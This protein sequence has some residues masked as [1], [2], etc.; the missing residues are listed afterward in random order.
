MSVKQGIIVPQGLK[1][2]IIGIE[3]NQNEAGNSMITVIF[4]EEFEGGLKINTKSNCAYVLP[5]CYLINITYGKESRTVKNSKSMFNCVLPPIR[6]K[7]N[8]KES[9]IA[10]RQKYEDPYYDESKNYW[11]KLT[12]GPNQYNNNNNN[13]Y[14]NYKKAAVQNG[15]PNKHINSFANRNQSPVPNSQDYQAIWS[16]IVSGKATTKKEAE[17]SQ[18]AFS[19]IPNS[20]QKPTKNKNKKEDPTPQQLQISLDKLNSYYSTKLKRYC[21][22]NFKV[23][24]K[25]TIKPNG[26]AHLNLTL[27]NE[28]PIFYKKAFDNPNDQRTIEEEM[29]KLALKKLNK[30][31]IK[32]PTFVLKDANLLHDYKIPSPP[33]N[34]F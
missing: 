15:V 9:F 23:E 18:S 20:V 28:Q 3:D 6:S 1:G 17:P 26:Q 27:P 32:P 2:V 4:D 33:E 24:P 31:T 21:K 7:Y 14:N 5:Q 12:N 19:L 10:P 13:H 25:I 11:A 8:Q 22:K 29:C 30:S 16:K 34:W